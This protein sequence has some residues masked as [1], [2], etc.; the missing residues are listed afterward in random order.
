M[1][2]TS[3]IYEWVSWQFNI[4]SPYIRPA[5]SQCSIEPYIFFRVLCCWKLNSCSG[6][7][8]HDNHGGRLYRDD[9]SG[10]DDGDTVTFI[11]GSELSLAKNAITSNQ[12][13]TTNTASPTSCVVSSSNV[14]HNLNHQQ[15]LTMSGP[16]A[17][18][19]FVILLFYF[20]LIELHL[21]SITFFSFKCYTY[22]ISVWNIG[23]KNKCAFN[24]ITIPKTYYLI[25]LN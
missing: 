22:K 15:P 3:S 1:C 10:S 25:H 20:F 24:L 4:Q 7:S 16:M 18:E 13:S 11:V 6:G 5:R 21:Y 9:S 12:T 8:L 2:K 14:V 23:L 17:S 19:R